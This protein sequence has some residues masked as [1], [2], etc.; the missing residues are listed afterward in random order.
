[1]MAWLWYLLLI[2]IQCLALLFT[3]MGLPG[4]WLMVGALA[5][6]AWVTR[7][8]TYVGWPGLVT[9]FVIATLAE[10]LEFFAGTAGA[11][12]AGASRRAMIG[13][14]VGALIG[15]LLLSIPVPILGTIF[16]VCL[17]AFIGAA[18]IEMGV[19]G[20]AGHAGLVGWGAAKG[21]FFGIVLKLFCGMLILLFSLFAAFPLH[22]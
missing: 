1:M 15:G 2:V 17:G 3:L 21:R 9:V 7:A 11:K 13:A 14:V 18:V 22:R 6:Y 12:R 5:A 16:G 8:G 4:L 19:I 10:V 20:D